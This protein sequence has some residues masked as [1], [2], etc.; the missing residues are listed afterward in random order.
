MKRPIWVTVI[1]VAAL[2]FAGQAMAGKNKS[3][4]KLGE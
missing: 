4:V 1:I 3:I 2:G